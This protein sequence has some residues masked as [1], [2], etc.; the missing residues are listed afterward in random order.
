MSGS[1]T[2]TP[3]NITTPRLG[4]N[5]PLVDGDIDVWGD[6]LNAN[7]DILDQSVT[8]AFGDGR[9]LGLAGG[10]VDP[11]PVSIGAGFAPRQFGQLEQLYT[12]AVSAR[13]IAFNLYADISAGSTWR[14]WSA[15]A[16]GLIGIDPVN[17]IMQFYMAPTGVVDAM[18]V[19]SYRFG[20]DTLGNVF[21][22][23]TLTSNG[24]HY[25]KAT[26][27][28]LHVDPTDTSPGQLVAERNGVIRWN[29]GF[30]NANPEAGGNQGS[31][32]TIA[33]YSDAGALLD[34]PVSIIRSTGYVWLGS[35]VNVGYARAPDYFL[36]IDA[37]GN[38]SVNFASGHTLYIDPTGNLNYWNSTNVGILADSVG[39]FEITGQATK[40]GGGPWSSASD[41]RIKRNVEPYTA[42]LDQVC[43][44]RPV[45]YAYNGMG[46]VI[47][48]GQRYYGLSAQLTRAVMPELVFEM[49]DN[50][51]IG[52][53]DAEDG[54]KLDSP[55]SPRLPGQL[56]TDLTA[57]PLALVN[58][59]QEL[60]ELVAGI[61]ARTSTLEGLVT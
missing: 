30:P 51:P 22:N 20:I 14:Y 50:G 29:I 59:V 17:G 61:D 31:D 1:G 35:R 3:F 60:R 38:R 37:S 23:G 55:H 18:A 58:A 56:A 26:Y 34:V 11:G 8:V 52:M 48:D 32:F 44:L 49:S 57:L 27:P 54:S 43:A 33:R 15:G 21:A 7:A 36:E 41:D 42:G 9:Y 12:S 10:Q 19:M 25:I 24:D 6:Y 16:G 39:N 28:T 4:L 46:G 13:N 47:D 5:K 40:P 53:P 45:S 2:P